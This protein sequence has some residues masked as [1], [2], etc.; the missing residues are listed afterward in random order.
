MTGSRT[1]CPNF[2][3]RTRF[4]SRIPQR[5]LLLLRCS[6][7]RRLDRSRH[8]TMTAVTTGVKIPGAVTTAA[9]GI[10]IADADT[11]TTAVMTVVMA[12]VTGIKEVGTALTTDV[13]VII[14]CIALHLVLH[15]GS[16]HGVDAGVAI[17]VTGRV[18][19]CLRRADK[20]LTQIGTIHCVP[21]IVSEWPRS[22]HGRR[23]KHNKGMS[24]WEASRTQKPPRTL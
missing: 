19:L 21:S 20:I 7:N 2:G 1:I 23:T 8:G 24:Q 3:K 5:K 13:T 15:P 10:K 16:L 11:A 14:G 4:S 12:A 6:N 9:T 17:P 22:T 18:R